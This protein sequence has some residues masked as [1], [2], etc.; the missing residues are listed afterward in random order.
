MT[1][2]KFT[3]FDLEN[4]LNDGKSLLEL[5]QRYYVLGKDLIPSQYLEDWSDI[6][7]VYIQWIKVK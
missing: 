2:D 7:P 3:A 1:R 5:Q 6:N 4:S